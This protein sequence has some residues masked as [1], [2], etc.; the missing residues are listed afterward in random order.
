MEQARWA[1]GKLRQA[2]STLDEVVINI[3]AKSLAL[4]S[5]VSIWIRSRHPDSK[6]QLREGGRALFAKDAQKPDTALRVKIKERLASSATAKRPMM[7]GVEHRA[8]ELK[9]SSRDNH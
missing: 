1:W 4:I 3:A 6:P 9:Q 5:R 2:S 7:P 8:S